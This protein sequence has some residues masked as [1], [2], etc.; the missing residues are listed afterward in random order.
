MLNNQKSD[1]QIKEISTICCA[2]CV[3]GDCP[4]HCSYIFCFVLVCYDC[5]LIF[6]LYGLSN[7]VLR[8][9][10]AYNKFLAAHC[11]LALLVLVP[12]RGSS[13]LASRD[14]VKCVLSPVP[15][16]YRTSC[17][18]LFH[19]SNVSRAILIRSAV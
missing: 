12:L 19:I 17:L 7:P 5:T 2:L 18:P 3:D 9:K 10:T 11:P 14:V 4:Q 13:L 1:D 6:Q 15:I 16:F 8:K